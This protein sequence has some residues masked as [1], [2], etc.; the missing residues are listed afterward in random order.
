M[1]DVPL[2]VSL[3]FILTTALTLFL[4]IRATNPPKIVVV[5]LILWLALQAYLGYSGFY[6]GVTTNP[7]RFLLAA[8]PTIVLILSVF[9]SKKGRSWT[10]TLSIKTL[11]LIHI[12]RIPVE[13]VLYLL[14]LYKMIPE[15]MTFS[16][17]NFDILAGVTAPIIYYLAFYRKAIGRTG[18]LLWNIFCLLLLLSIIGNAVLSTP[19]PIQQF[20]FDQPNLAILHFPVVW[21][22][23]FVVPVVL[24]S[25]VVSIYRLIKAEIH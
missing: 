5:G 3:I 17:R 6:L 14:F 7:F 18:L 4:F 16:G 24:F 8:P 2:Y 21:L 10:Q 9:I 11:T 1:Q 13:L 22:P 12:V 25:H 20:A 23:T 19:I 15:L